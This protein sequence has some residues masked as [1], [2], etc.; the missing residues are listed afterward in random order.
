MIVFNNNN[1]SNKNTSDLYKDS[2]F[3]HSRS[4]EQEAEKSVRHSLTKNNRD[5]LKNLGF[6][7]KL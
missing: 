4:K 6:R 1:S 2:S 5:F 3:T 7:L